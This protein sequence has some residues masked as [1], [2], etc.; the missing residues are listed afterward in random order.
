LAARRWATEGRVQNL[1]KVEMDCGWEM[2][3]ARR[4]VAAEKSWAADSKKAVQKAWEPIGR[5]RRH[6][7]IQMQGRRGEREGA[8]KAGKLGWCQSNGGGVGRRDGEN[9]C[10]CFVEKNAYWGS[11]ALAGFDE[12]GELLIW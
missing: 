4:F 8:L 10:L 12:E 5:P 3:L 2:R 7:C 6:W 1:N 11:E 9:V